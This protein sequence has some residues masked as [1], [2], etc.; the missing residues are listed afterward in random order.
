M[1]AL[2]EET[3]RAA[4]WLTGQKWALAEPLGYEDFRPKSDI[5]Q[6]RRMLRDVPT[7]LMEGVVA[8]LVSGATVTDPRVE[9]KV[10]DGSWTHCKLWWT[11]AGEGTDDHRLILFQLLSSGTGAGTAHVVENGCAYIVTQTFFAPRRRPSISACPVSRWPL[12]P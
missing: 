3:T 4:G 5:R 11:R 7:E 2:A 6:L 9:G 12:M 8:S 10:F 1:A